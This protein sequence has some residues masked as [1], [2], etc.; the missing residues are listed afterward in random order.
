MVGVSQ[1][2]LGLGIIAQITMEYAFHSGC[3]ADGHKNGSLNRAVVGLDKTSA[4]LRLRI[5]M[6]KRKFHKN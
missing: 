5:G 2:Y 3:S 6:L 1:N 4:R